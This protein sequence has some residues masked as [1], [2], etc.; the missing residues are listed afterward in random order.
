MASNPEHNASD[1]CFLRGRL[2]VLLLLTLGVVLH[3]H[4]PT[5]QHFCFNLT[6]IQ[7][8]E[9]QATMAVSTTSQ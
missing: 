5:R 7:S 1:S 9:Q 3:S 4:L 8:Q 6:V 2:T